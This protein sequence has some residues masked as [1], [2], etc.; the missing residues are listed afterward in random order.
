MAVLDFTLLLNPAHHFCRCHSRWRRILRAKF[1]SG[2][3]HLDLN[4]PHGSYKGGERE[5]AIRRAVEICCQGPIIVVT[6]RLI[7]G[8]NVAAKW[9]PAPAILHRETHI[10]KRRKL[11]TCEFKNCKMDALR[12]YCS[13]LYYTLMVSNYLVT[14]SL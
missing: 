2:L 10:S 6:N 14:R 1:E 7:R 9:N 11:L 5:L 13:Y 8:Q 4:P 3:P 12:G